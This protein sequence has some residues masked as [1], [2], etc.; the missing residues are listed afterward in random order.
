MWYNIGTEKQ[1]LHQLVSIGT[2]KS[3]DAQKAFNSLDQDCFTDYA[4]KYV[5]N[6]IQERYIKREPF[7]YFQLLDLTRNANTSIITLVDS[8]EPSQYISKNLMPYNIKSLNE[9][10]ILRKQAKIV[11]GDDFNPKAIPDVGSARE[12]LSERLTEALKLNSQTE[13]ELYSHEKLTDMHLTGQLKIVK[14]MKT[15]ITQIDKICGLP[16]SALTTIAAASGVGKTSFGLMLFINTL[17]ENPDSYGLFFN[18]EVAKEKLYPKILNQKAQGYF[19]LLEPDERSYHLAKLMHKYSISSEKSLEDI[20]IICRM[21][22]QHKNLKVV[23]IDHIGNVNCKG[24]FENYNLKMTHI[25]TFLT[26]L[27]IE[28]NC[29]IILLTQVNKE[30]QKKQDRCPEPYD[31]IYTSA[32]EHYSEIWIGLDKPS[33]HQNDEMHKTTFKHT[34]IAKIRKN[35][36]GSN[37]S[38]AMV[39]EYG[40]GGCILEPEYDYDDYIRQ[41]QGVQEQTPMSQT[42]YAKRKY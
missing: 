36:Y 3:L 33:N 41:T 6:L 22:A 29:A 1:I 18:L 28:L 5:F 16:L 15:G 8:F 21:E 34:L 24:K 2:Y 13:L 20:A 14:P 27:A 17:V 38:P 19:D 10:S 26:D 7:D 4:T 35:R 31:A 25:I 30:A 37:A 32:T 9:A 11:F 23:V 42:P 40:Q 12:V 39:F